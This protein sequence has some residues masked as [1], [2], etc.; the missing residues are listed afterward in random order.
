MLVKKHVYPIQRA[1]QI[2]YLT[3]LTV[4]KRATISGRAKGDR[5]HAPILQ[6][7]FCHVFFQA[8]NVSKPF[9]GRVAAPDP[10]GE[11]M[12]LSQIP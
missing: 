6:T 12:T 10:T 2:R 3:R 8:K 1:A 11:L 7:I 5:G 4:N 9:F